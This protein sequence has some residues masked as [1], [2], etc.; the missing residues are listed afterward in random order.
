MPSP[1]PTA[2]APHND[3][4]QGWPL[5]AASTPART[6]A[7]CVLWLGTAPFVCAVA[8][9]AAAAKQAAAPD[10]AA[11]AAAVIIPCLTSYAAMI[12]AFIGGLEQA[13]AL[14]GEEPRLVIA[15]VALALGGWLLVMRQQMRAA[16]CLAGG[17]A[18]AE[19]QVEL[20]LLAVLYGWQAWVES[21][22]ERWRTL[23]SAGLLQS[24]GRLP[25]MAVAALCLLAASRYAADTGSTHGSTHHGGGDDGVAAASAAA[26]VEAK[27]A[28]DGHGG[29][30]GSAL[31]GLG[32]RWVDDSY[33]TAAMTT[34]L[35]AL[36][37]AALG[38]SGPPPPSS[39]RE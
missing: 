25:A 33:V 5:L 24:R 26:A 15:G 10:S 18:L 31:L 36:L 1:S 23:S 8:A 19:P 37:G 29:E 11:T 21:C 30:E 2:T 27:S 9:L 6:V 39:A 22:G 3:M 35:L 13:A 32:S 17:S 34:T 20:L 4:D 7:T 28:A 12:L 14:A 16:G 38:A